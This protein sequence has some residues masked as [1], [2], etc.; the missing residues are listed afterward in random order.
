MRKIG[1]VLGALC[2]LS[3]AN[4]QAQTLAVS[5]EAGV[6]VTQLTTPGQYWG[7]RTG[8]LLGASASVSLTSWLAV[9]AGVRVHEQGAAVPGDFEMRIRYL[10]VPVLARISIGRTDWLVRPVVMGGVA[11]ST[12]L[13]CAAQVVPGSGNLQAPLPPTQP[14]QPIDCIAWR[15]DLF[16]YSAVVGAGVEIRLGRLRAALV[17]QYARGTHNIAS[18]ETR[19][20]PGFYVY[21]RATSVVFSVGVPVWQRR[22]SN[23]RLQRAGA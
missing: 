21:N 7:S 4:L 1:L 20:S 3:N 19:L 13:S 14:M 10:E 22:P 5:T 15:T 12:E 17:G 11:R 18:G 16:D 6:S 9:Q 8:Y 23:Q 2:V